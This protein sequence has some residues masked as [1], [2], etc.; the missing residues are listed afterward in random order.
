MLTYNFIKTTYE[1]SL[2]SE[3]V[4]WFTVPFPF[5]NLNLISFLRLLCY[6]FIMQSSFGFYRSSLIILLVHLHQ[7][8]R[9]HYL[10]NFYP[11]AHTLSVFIILI[12]NLILLVYIFIM[13]DLYLVFI[14]N[15][16]FLWFEGQAFLYPR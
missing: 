15:I 4:D 14:I 16:I 12:L 11:L 6:I 5:P 13:Q 3:I 2:D 9:S 8:L 10:I 7:V 1:F